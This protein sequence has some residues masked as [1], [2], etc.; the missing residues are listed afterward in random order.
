[1]MALWTSSELAEAVGGKASEIFEANGVAFDSREV[2]KGDL[3]FALK[4]E[5]SDGHLYLDKVYA[6]GGAGAIVSEATDG[7]HIL[8]DDTTDALNALAKAS[9]SRTGAKII[10]VT[11]SVGKTGTKEALFAALERSSMG[12]AHRSLK[13]YNNHVGVPLSLSRMPADTEFGIFEM[14]MNHAGELSR[15]T[16]LVRPDVAIITAIAPAHIGHFSSVE[17]IADAKAEIFEGLTAVGTAVIPF[18]SPHYERLKSAALKHTQNILSFGFSEQADVRAVDIVPAPRGGSLVTASLGDQ[19]LCFTIS[20]PGRHWVSN[21]LAVLAAVRAAG[22]DLASAG[23]ALAELEG[24]AGRGKRHKLSLV[25][26]GSALLIDE[27]YN[28]NPVSMKATLA[29]LASE[30]GK[31]K[32]ITVL[33]AMGELGEAARAYHEALAEDIA[34]SGA[35]IIILVGDEMA[36]TA[37]KLDE[38]L[39]HNAEIFHAASSSDALTEVAKQIGDGDILLIKGSNYLGL[40]SVV[41]ALVNGEY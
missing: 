3:F 12:K 41:S 37:A 34:A 18:D 10:G 21:A 14:G 35:S 6:A 20:E 32:K 38:A 16:Q 23:L 9:R 1:M 2:G 30:A 28:A 13:S 24:L 36:H 27:S 40:A 33:G 8:V 15:L 22:G 4:G 31:G 39:D 29:Q 26:G 5:Q 17:E 7:P 25:S 11:G 19:S